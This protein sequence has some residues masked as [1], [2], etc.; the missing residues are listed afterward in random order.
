[1][2]AAA[3]RAE[4]PY[5][6]LR[7]FE[8]EE[9]YLFFGRERVIDQLLARLRETRFLAVIGSS[10][11]GKSSVV[12]AGMVPSLYSGYMAQAGSSWRVAI[13][14][15]GVAPLSNLV[16]ALDA[17]GVLPGE[18][19]GYG[20][21]RMLAETTLRRSNLGLV[22]CLR[23]ARLPAQENVLVVVDQFEELFRFTRVSSADG[24]REEGIAFVK[25]LLSAAQQ[26]ELPIYIA[27]TMRAEFLG[28][29]TRIP[30]LPDAINAGQFLV[31]RMDRQEMRDAITGPAAVSGVSIAPR[32]VV[33]LLNEVGDDP[34]QLP[35]LQHALMR[36]WDNW[37]G[38]RTPERA[39]DFEHY[40]AIG[41]L[42][43][44]LSQ[45]AEEAYG[46]L[47]SDRSRRLA[48]QLFRALIDPGS[49]N[50]MTRRPN[51]VA[52]LA[53]IAQASQQQVCEVV[54]CFRRAGRSFLMPPPDVTLN[55]DTMIDLSHE[56]LARIWRRLVLWA[57]AERESVELLRWLI[58]A[59]EHYHGGSGGLWRDPELAFGL[60]W[61]ERQQPTQAWAAQY[62]PGL[63]PALAFLDASCKERD[64]EAAERRR[65]RA[66]RLL[67]AWG[68]A[69]VLLVFAL[70]ALFQQ[71]QAEQARR[72]AEANL[73][74]A[75]QS[76]DEMMI[77]V[78]RE[79]LADV[80]QMENV[81]NEL[82]LKARDFY[83]GFEQQDP[84]DLGLATDAA[85][86]HLHIADIDRLRGLP[87]EA[88][89]SYEAGIADLRELEQL[90]DLSAQQRLELVNA[91]DKLGEHLTGI[92]RKGAEAAFDEAIARGSA[93][94]EAD[95][96][97][98]AFRHILG[99]SH[100]NRGILLARIPERR[101]DG[102][103]SFRK[104]IALLEGIRQYDELAAA[105]FILAKTWNN[106]ANL[107]KGME[108]WDAADAS[109]H[110]SIEQFLTLA[111]QHPY[112]REYRED[113]ARTWNNLAN[114][115]LR[116]SQLDAALGAN[117]EA[118][119]LLAELAEP[120]PSLR[121]ELANTY[122]SRGV[123]LEQLTA[124]FPG[125]E[126]DSSRTAAEAYGR[127]LDLL[128]SIEAETP[129][130]ARNPELNQRSGNALANLARLR[131]RDG[132]FKGA[133]ELLLQAEAYHLRAVNSASSAAQ[134]VRSLSDTYWL[135]EEAGMRA[136]DFQAAAAAAL[137][138]GENVPQADA[139]YRA[140]RVLAQAA[141]AAGKTLGDEYARGAVSYLSRALAAGLPPQRLQP[142]SGA[143]DPFADLRNREDF[144]DL[145]ERSTIA[146]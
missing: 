57:A 15:P 81:R 97:P 70:L 137:R 105:Q 106:L 6:G 64:R 13:C 123:I 134:Y 121:S 124:A 109:Y 95:P 99:R 115:H 23:Q 144:K 43:H 79:S 49:D 59:T 122:N 66:N 139:Q 129:D 22:E 28:D 108:Q 73:Q 80:P 127:A 110:K 78:G 19:D 62:A 7:P 67:L 11:C 125:R 12:R 142:E 10:G 71:R 68:T 131:L 85:L 76:V 111:R 90:H 55:A 48:E 86:A 16:A 74:V 103:A 20:T 9:D 136:G 104:A 118:V 17:P 133:S 30:G 87:A 84:D 1:V 56:S 53:E 75:R 145:V 29:C 113:L 117:G 36:T 40:E 82:L 102:E 146:R 4:N 138:H 24:S 32:L 141:H 5:P 94:L 26:D 120:I 31:P 101:D 44:A 88:T 140:A 107:Q 50:R 47:D 72:L 38:C 61:L 91:Y 89:A 119:T 77:A 33:R 42:R 21:R 92:D 83:Q 8:A 96:D 58:D 51:S 69:G 114:L 25:R 27:L 135:L 98:P 128:R 41:T 45:H 60:R 54:E 18:D 52:S 37:H 112:K 46:E 35:V 2:I 100:N 93:L 130:L 63:E 132:E 116:N 14:R 65:H 3:A 39:L 34:D 126:Q 143:M